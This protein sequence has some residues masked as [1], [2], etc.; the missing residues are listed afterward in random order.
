LRSFDSSTINFFQ[1]LVAGAAAHQAA[2]RHGTADLVAEHVVDDEIVS[3]VNEVRVGH[4]LP[5]VRVQR[6]VQ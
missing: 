6:Q 5:P 2:Q 1:G 3:D 4:P